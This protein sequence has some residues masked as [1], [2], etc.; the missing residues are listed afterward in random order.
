MEL[1]IPTDFTLAEDLQVVQ[2]THL[3]HVITPSSDIP[4][5]KSSNPVMLCAVIVHI[6][7]M[8]CIMNDTGEG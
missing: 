7:Y 1:C 5:V 8:Y 3:N 4:G 6:N 2:E